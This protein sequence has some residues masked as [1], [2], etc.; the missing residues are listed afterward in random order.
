MLP[1]IDSTAIP[2]ITIDPAGASDLDQAL[3]LERREHGYRI[4]YVIADVPAFVAPNGPIDAEV[5]RRGQTIYAP[6]GRIPLHPTV[7]SE[8]AASLLPGEVRSAFVWSFELDAAA[9][10][11]AVTVARERIRSIR[12]CDYAEVRHGIDAGTASDSLP[13]LRE[14]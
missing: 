12:Q 4:W 13:L 10:V 8:D 1:D 6:D 2:F 9:N 7:I 11:T 14:V 5:R 3:H